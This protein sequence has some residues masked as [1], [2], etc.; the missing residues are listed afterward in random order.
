MGAVIE[1]TRGD[2]AHHKF[3]I[4]ASSWSA[5]GK[6]WFG[7]KQVIDDDTADTAMVLK[8]HWD[9]SAV[10]DVTIGGVAY[11]EYACNWSKTD[12]D[13]IPSNGA[14]SLDF[15]GEFQWV[16][17]TGDP[18]TFPATD[19]KLDCKVYFDIIRETA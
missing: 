5:G 13:D 6:L 14:S 12:T 9:D 11:K 2:G 19:D 1:F 18:I 3:R 17:L 8:K 16:P 10:N 7:A 15:I 4:P